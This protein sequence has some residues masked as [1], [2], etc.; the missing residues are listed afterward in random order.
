M[1]QTHQKNQ[2]LL[3]RPSRRRREIGK[4][5][6]KESQQSKLDA[7]NSVIDDLHPLIMTNFLHIGSYMSCHLIKRLMKHIYTPFYNRYIVILYQEFVHYPPI[8]YLYHV[9]FVNVQIRAISKLHNLWSNMYVY[10]DVIFLLAIKH[11]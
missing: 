4:R 7:V 3:R 5:K 9:L 11:V 2:S 6:T 10:T 8:G 1:A